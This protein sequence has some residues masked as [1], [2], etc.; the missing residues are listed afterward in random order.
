MPSKAAMW[1][2][3]YIT[4]R[5]A[6]ERE[7]RRRVEAE[8]AQHAA[9]AA[10]EQL[11]VRRVHRD[12]GERAATRPHT[13][14]GIAAEHLDRLFTPFDRLGADSEEGVGLG[15]PLAR[16]LTEA[17][18]GTLDVQSTVGAGTVVT[19]VLPRSAPPDG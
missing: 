13:G 9:E 4:G 12:S 8:L 6:A 7:R 17:M 15:L 16:G 1:P 2:H 14:Q 11:F 19:V 5:R 18:G 3:H 10:S